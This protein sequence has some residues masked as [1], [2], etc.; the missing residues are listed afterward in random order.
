MGQVE[1]QVGGLSDFRRS[2]DSARTHSDRQIE[3]LVDDAAGVVL[4]NARS[5]VPRGPTGAAR[6]SLRIVEGS[7]TSQLVGG[8]RRAPY[9]GWLDFGGVAGRRG[10]RRPYKPRGRYILRALFD[11][12]QEL[13]RM[14]DQAGQNVITGSGLG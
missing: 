1:I 5:R 14:I 2:L 10:P 6:A 3:L 7:G 12:E 11:R 8:S 4:Q 9:Y 13:G